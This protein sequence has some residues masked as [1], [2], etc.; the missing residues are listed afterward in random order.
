MVLRQ[1]EFGVDFKVA[2]KTGRGIFAGIDDEPAAAAAHLDVPAARAMARFTAALAGHRRGFHVDARMRAGRKNP[3]VIGVTVEAG[4]VAHV[5]RAG[6]FRR[7]GDQVRRGRTR[8]Q[9]ASHGAGKR[10]G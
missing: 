4:L 8:D 3:D 10:E 2:L 6:D 9:Q 5:M 1:I 7:T